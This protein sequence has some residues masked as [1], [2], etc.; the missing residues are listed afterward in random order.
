[1]YEAYHDVWP[2]RQAANDDRQLTD[3]VGPVCET[4]DTFARA[5]P[6]API[7]AG[8]LVALMTAGA[9]GAV[10]ASTYNAR[11]LAPEVLVDGDRWALVRKPWTV[12]E[13]MLLETA[14][15]WLGA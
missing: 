4:G 8:E 7:A 3:I 15:P 2:V 12:E 1:M 13:Q 5:R 10:M 9:Y 14:P 6:L 11:T